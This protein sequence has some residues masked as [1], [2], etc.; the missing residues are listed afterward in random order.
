M[1]YTQGV[2]ELNLL[3]PTGQLLISVLNYKFK[4]SALV[5]RYCYI[6]NVYLAPK[7]IESILLLFIYYYYFLPPPRVWWS[8]QTAGGGRIGG[9]GVLL[10]RRSWGRVF[11][12]VV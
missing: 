12:V 5:Q 10:L 3:L 8:W 9:R 4:K 6:Q 2:Y 11:I 7:I 1:I